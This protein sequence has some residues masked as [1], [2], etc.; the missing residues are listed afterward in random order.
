MEK[1]IKKTIVTDQ[2]IE[3]ESNKKYTLRLNSAA[4]KTLHK[5]KKEEGSNFRFIIN[6][7]IRKLPPIDYIDYFK[8]MSTIRK[9][10]DEERAV[11]ISNILLDDINRERLNTEMINMENYAII[12]KHRITKLP[13][14]LNYIIVKY[15][16]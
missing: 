9:R 7:A 10:K 12:N 16:K 6:N 11:Y 15:V 1:S 8:Y 2:Q 3:E 14:L 4:H 13:A 5:Y